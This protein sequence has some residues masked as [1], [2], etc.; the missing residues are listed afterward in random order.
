M[1]RLVVTTPN[2][3]SEWAAEHIGAQLSEWQRDPSGRALVLQSGLQLAT[4]G[5]L[6]FRLGLN[7]GPLDGI[8]LDITIPTLDDLPAQLDYEGGRYLPWIADNGGW[9]HSTNNDPCYRW[10]A[11][12]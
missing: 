11:S 7:E 12:A 5:G 3:L 9:M 4:I 6:H 8:N 10:E 1:P 2:D